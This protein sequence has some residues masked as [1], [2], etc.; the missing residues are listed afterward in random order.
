MFGLMKMFGRVLVFGGVAAAHVP[1]DHAKAKVNPLVARL[2][3]LFAAVGV[4]PNI[5]DLI[6]MG[7]VVHG[8]RRF[9]HI[10]NHGRFH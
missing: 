6:E 9:D 1:A 7:T 4:G 2:Q 3:A 5:L 10:V 8:G